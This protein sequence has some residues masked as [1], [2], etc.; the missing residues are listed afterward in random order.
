MSYQNPDRST[1]A[2]EGSFAPRLLFVVNSDWFFLSHRLALAQRAREA[3]YDVHVATLDTGKAEAIRE[4]GFPFYPLSMSRQGM[5]PLKELE[6]VLGLLRLYRDCRPD[7]VHHVTPKPVLYGSLAA[8]LVPGLAVVNAVTGMGHLFTDTT[9]TTLLQ[10]TVRGMYAVALR[11]PLSRTIFQNGDDYAEFTNLGLVAPARAEVIRGS[12]VDCERF[13]PRPSPG[14][15]PI[16][17]MVARMLWDKGIG[18]FV[19]A[20]RRLRGKGV[21]CR[22]V[23]VGAPD[24][25]NP[26]SVPEDRLRA[27]ADAGDVEWWGY[28]TDVPALL[29]SASVVVLPSYYRE[30]LPKSLLE[31]AACA[32]PLVATD[33]PGCREVV[34]DGVTGLLVPPRDPEALGAAVA[35][36]LSDPDKRSRLGLAAREVA[37]QEFEEG[38]IIRA[39]MGVYRRLLAERRTQGVVALSPSG[40]RRRVPSGSA[41]STE[42]PV[43]PQQR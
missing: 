35:E 23:L 26:T 22:F 20:A 42:S 37:I 29:A 4:E 19:E 12:G 21:N 28:H 8:R 7:I 40:R 32:R 43:S 34:R 38:L 11:H 10:R 6:S 31:A 14:G 30:G 24:P 27:W 9:R 2:A 18:E 33:V 15:T 16:V 17:M 25:G 3:G 39:T 36:L 13:F 5:H 1:S 41:L